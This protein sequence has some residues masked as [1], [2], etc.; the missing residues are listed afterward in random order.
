MIVKDFVLSRS[1]AFAETLVE[2]WVFDQRIV[3]SNLRIEAHECC[4]G[5]RAGSSALIGGSAA[6]AKENAERAR[7]E[8]AERLSRLSR[9]MPRYLCH[10]PSIRFPLVRHDVTELLLIGRQKF[11]VGSNTDARNGRVIALPHGFS[12]YLKR[13]SC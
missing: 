9:R 12:T 13:T 5:T 7:S 1:V 6:R 4:G 11:A 10:W 3:I 2:R 8:D